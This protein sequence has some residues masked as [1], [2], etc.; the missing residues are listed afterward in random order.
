MNIL[1]V[2]FDKLSFFEIDP[3]VIYNRD[4]LQKIS[5]EELYGVIAI[6][7]SILNN[8]EQILEIRRRI[9]DPNG[10]AKFYETFVRNL[11][12]NT[13]KSDENDA[14]IRQALTNAAAEIILVLYPF[15]FKELQ[16]TGKG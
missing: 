6:Y 12:L 13:E 1:P 2:N 16:P 14:K 7:F 9:S 4:Q 10:T 15:I 3:K 11:A 5:L 8:N